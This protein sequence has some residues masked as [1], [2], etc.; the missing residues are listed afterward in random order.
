[1]EEIKTKR[2]WGYSITEYIFQ[3]F[4]KNQKE[5]TIIDWLERAE[6]ATV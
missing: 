2:T 5:I 1:M 3:Q 6:E 4:L